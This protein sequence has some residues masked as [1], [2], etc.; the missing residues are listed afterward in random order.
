MADKVDIFLAFYVADYLADTMDLSTEEHGAYVLLLCAMWRNDGWV[1]NDPA[2]LASITKV[3][4]KRWPVVWAALERFFDV[5]D[6]K[7]SQRRL[8]REIKNAQS[9]LIAARENGRRGGL[10][11]ARVARNP[12]QVYQPSANHSATSEPLA[13]GLANPGS[14]PSPSDPE[15]S[16]PRDPAVLVAGPVTGPM[17]T[18]LFGRARAALWPEALEWAGTPT[19]PEKAA[20][21]AATIPPSAIASVPITMNMLLSRAKAGTHRK[22]ADIVKSPGFAFVCWCNE[23][24]DLLEEILG[25]TPAAPP[26]NGANGHKRDQRTGYA[27]PPPAGTP[28]PSGKVHLR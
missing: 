19:N 14:S 16:L 22:A 24:H 4:G 10:A 27:E 20:N 18:Q 13:K 26:T 11:K 6:G 2:R 1:A 9:R 3:P 25:K 12:L 15:R 5:K 21:M 17:L 23:F 7:L 8:L 28:Y